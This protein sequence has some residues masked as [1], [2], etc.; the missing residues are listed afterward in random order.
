[1]SA[2]RFPLLWRGRGPA[3]GET[4]GGWYLWEGPGQTPHPIRWLP[5]SQKGERPYLVVG[6]GLPELVEAGIVQPGRGDVPLSQEP[7]TVTGWEVRRHGKQGRTSR[8][9]G[10]SVWDLPWAPER[11]ML[12][13]EELIEALDESGFSHIKSPAELGVKLAVRRLR[14]G[15]LPPRYRE[16]ARAAVCSGPMLMCRPKGS[17]IEEWDLRRAFLEGLRGPLP[18]LDSWRPASGMPWSELREQAGIVSASVYLDRA[19]DVHPLPCWHNG[20][21]VFARGMLCGTWTVRALRW[22]EDRLGAQ[23][24]ALHDGAICDESDVALAEAIEDL[25]ECLQ[26]LVYTRLWG[27]ACSLGGWE[28]DER[29]LSGAWSWRWTGGARLGDTRDPFHRPD[30]AAWVTGRALVAVSELAAVLLPGEL[31]A[32]HVDALWIEWSQERAGAL[33]ACDWA[34]WARKG[35]PAFGTWYGVGWYDFAGFRARMGLPAWERAQTAPSVAPTMRP[36]ASAALL[37]RDWAHVWGPLDLE[38][39]LEAIPEWSTSAPLTLDEGREVTFNAPSWD[40]HL[41]GPSNYPARL[42]WEEAEVPT[43]TVKAGTGAL[44]VPM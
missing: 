27:R 30:V 13:A 15:P 41:W 21:R 16:P 32:A 12:Q 33:P 1:M 4:E 28:G 35:G 2:P 10:A 3:S 31:V 34:A 36:E 43:R 29:D 14:R 20:I 22:A 5:P 9:R 17:T 11:A 6:P 40:G 37:G 19:P 39:N 38:S 18:R 7:P 23:V 8:I 26:R 42:E 24:V 44:W 25:P